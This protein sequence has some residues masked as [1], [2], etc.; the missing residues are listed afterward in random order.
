MEYEVL[1]FIWWAL[2]GVL[3]I[4]LMVM[5]GHD[6]GVGTLSPFFGKTDNQ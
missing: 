2:I 4:G 6:M 5:D 3:L 1:R